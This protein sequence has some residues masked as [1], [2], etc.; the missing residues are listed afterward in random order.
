MWIKHATRNSLAMGP[1]GLVHTVAGSVAGT[2]YTPTV[3]EARIPSK[4]IQIGDVETSSGENMSYFTDSDSDSEH[5]RPKMIDG[6]ASFPFFSAMNGSIPDI[7]TPAADY[8]LDVMRSMSAEQSQ[9]NSL[10]R[11]SVSFSDIQ[12]VISNDDHI[13]WENFTYGSKPVDD[14]NKNFQVQWD[15][16]VEGNGE[17][18][19]S[20]DVEAGRGSDNGGEE[21]GGGETTA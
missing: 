4:F 9:T 17:S 16:P 2:S 20:D 19:S 12:Q 13:G 18:G 3:A 10:M 14:S 7:L 11:R 5:F 15:F 21:G 8:E 6:G 1:G